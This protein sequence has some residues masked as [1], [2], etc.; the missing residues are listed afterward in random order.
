MKN[1]AITEI[2]KTFFARTDTVS[3]PKLFHLSGKDFNFDWEKISCSEWFKGQRKNLMFLAFPI[4][5]L[6]FFV[7]FN[8]MESGAGDPIIGLF[9]IFASAISTMFVAK[10]LQIS[11]IH[12]MWKKNIPAVAEFAQSP[13]QNFM[14][15]HAEAC[16][17]RVKGMQVIAREAFGEI[18]P[19]DKILLFLEFG[20]SLAEIPQDWL[21]KYSYQG[22]ARMVWEKMAEI[23]K[24]YG[25]VLG[26]WDAAAFAEKRPQL[27]DFLEPTLR[28]FLIAWWT[29]IEFIERIGYAHVFEAWRELSEKHILRYRGMIEK[30]LDG[31]MAVAYKP[32]R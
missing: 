2:A 12:P 22:S 26:K 28:E 20:L 31:I 1:P 17:N 10:L 13:T 11:L 5:M 27:F 18:I 7:V 16:Q 30:D 21:A 24:E 9:V 6:F 25:G 8:L 3:L 29:H 4:C 19:G 14:Q 15:L 32:V 23:Y